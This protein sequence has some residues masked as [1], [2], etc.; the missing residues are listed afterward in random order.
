MHVRPERDQRELAAHQQALAHLVNHI[1]R[2]TE[3]CVPLHGGPQWHARIVLPHPTRGDVTAKAIGETREEAIE[4]ARLATLPQLKEHFLH[5]SVRATPGAEPGPGT[6]TPTGADRSP[7]ALPDVARALA[8]AG[9]GALDPADEPEV[10]KR[11][12]PPT[13][14][15]QDTLFA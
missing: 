13:A 10:P 3:L 4:R 8:D 9:A 1:A 5:A 14:A 11:W 15:A 12:R 7:C 6:Q 2:A